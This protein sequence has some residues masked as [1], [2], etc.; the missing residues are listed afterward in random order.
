MCFEL[1]WGQLARRLRPFLPPPLKPCP[2]Y[3]DFAHV[4]ALPEQLLVPSQFTLRAFRDPPAP[5]L[6]AREAALSVSILSSRGGWGSQPGPE[7]HPPAPPTH[8]SVFPLPDPLRLL[9][10]SLQ[11]LPSRT[12]FLSICCLDCSQ[13]NCLMCLTLI[14]RARW[15]LHIAPNP[16]SLSPEPQE[17]IL[18]GAIGVREQG[19]GYEGPGTRQGPSGFWGSRVSL[20]CQSSPS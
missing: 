10:S 8:P 6:I 15:W 9:G 13:M 12:S 20:T 11:N 16:L 3:Q 5:G 17:S 2:G 14:A 19:G 7:H 1:S 18:S 4:W